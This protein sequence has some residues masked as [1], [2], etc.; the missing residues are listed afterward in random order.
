ML[1]VRA[2]QAGRHG[3]NLRANMSSKKGFQVQVPKRI[4]FYTG[5]VFLVLPLVLF[6]REEKHI[7]NNGDLAQHDDKFVREHPDM[8]LHGGHELNAD[9]LRRNP[10]K[11][12][13]NKNKANKESLQQLLG[14]NATSPSNSRKEGSEKI[15]L[16]EASS[17]SK[18]TEIN[19]VA[20]ASNTTDT[21][22][23]DKDT[24]A[25]E[26]QQVQQEQVQQQQEQEQQEQED[27]AQ[28]SQEQQH[29]DTGQDQDP[30]EDNTAPPVTEGDPDK[31]LLEDAK[32]EKEAEIDPPPTAA[33]E[34]NETNDNISHDEER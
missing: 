34:A 24:D 28:V 13:R 32:A 23:T 21:I 5:L 11:K 2:K 17:T 20:M 6:F 12:T 29:V 18:P 31:V 14:V 8:P 26:Q 1:K 7:H 25:A 16:P 3:Y 9:H 33:D 15:L 30:K 10:T 4:L 27:K 19:T 22:D